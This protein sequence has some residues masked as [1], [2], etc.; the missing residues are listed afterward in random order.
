M[1]LM[2]SS[3]SFIAVGVI[4]AVIIGIAVAGVLYQ[5]N[6]I[7]GTKIHPGEDQN[8]TRVINERIENITDSVE[9]NIN[10][11]DSNYDSKRPRDWI[12]SGPFEIDRKEYA[13][14]EQVLLRINNIPYNEKGQVAFMRPVNA[15]HYE[16]YITIPFDGT[17][18]GAFNQYFKPAL[19]RGKAI[20]SVQDLAG[21][22][23]VI[24]RGTDYPNLTFTVND[25]M[26]VPGD[27]ENYKPIC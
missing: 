27:E 12:A 6:P 15:T 13:L 2:G 22:W 8:T 4:V 1:V 11:T 7:N 19:S 21:Q 14:G 16:V 20:C 17:D 10:N 3:K 23:V 26:I 25:Q 9:N 5:N 24:F 18:K